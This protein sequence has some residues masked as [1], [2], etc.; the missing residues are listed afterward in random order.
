MEDVNGN[1][2]TYVA[3][4]FAEKTGYIKFG[5]VYNGNGNGNGNFVL[6]LNQH[7]F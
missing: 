3:Y 1:G 6:V 2:G 4:V 7:F 5:Y